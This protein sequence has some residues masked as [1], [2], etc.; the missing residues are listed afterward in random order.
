MASGEF[1]G[2]ATKSRQRW[3][4]AGSQR[5]ATYSSFDEAFGD[6]DVR[7]RIDQRDVG[8]GRSCRW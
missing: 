5:S 8:A 3:N 2:C 4:G 7:E 6:D 1:F